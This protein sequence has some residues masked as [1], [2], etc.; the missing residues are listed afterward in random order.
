MYRFLLTA[1]RGLGYRRCVAAAEAA[2][3]DL[4]RWTQIQSS[5]F[6]EEIE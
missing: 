6:G 4:G 5:A 3:R 1:V 2:A